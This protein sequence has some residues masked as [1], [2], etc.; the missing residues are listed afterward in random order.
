MAVAPGPASERLVAVLQY[1]AA[2]PVVVFARVPSRLERVLGEGSVANTLSSP[3]FARAFPHSIR[4]QNA[5]SYYWPCEHTSSSESTIGGIPNEFVTG[6]GIG[7]GAC[8]C[9]ANDFPGDILIISDEFCF[10]I[11]FIDCLETY[12][13]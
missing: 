5:L 12:S 8:R 6:S 4:R 7:V 3:S 11:S 2:P 1:A 10:K 9:F 13:V